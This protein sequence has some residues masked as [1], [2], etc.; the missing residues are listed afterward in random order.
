M[1][2]LQIV[3]AESRWVAEIKEGTETL[4]VACWAL[5]EVE[6]EKEEIQKHR[7]IADSKQAVIGLVVTSGGL[8]QNARSMTGFR[9]YIQTEK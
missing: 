4:P 2:I 3:P 9:G 7:P 5:I 8:L 6:P 1:R